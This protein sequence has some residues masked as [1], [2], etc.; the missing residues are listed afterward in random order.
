M[1]VKNEIGDGGFKCWLCSRRACFIAGGAAVISSVL[2][3]LYRYYR[4]GR[5]NDLSKDEGFVDA[6]KVS[7]AGC[8]RLGE[9]PVGRKTFGRIIFLGDRRLGD[10]S[11]FKKDVSAKDG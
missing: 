7:L 11:H 4:S 1:A 9:K 5:D 3:A 10:N 6:A 8:R 2:Y